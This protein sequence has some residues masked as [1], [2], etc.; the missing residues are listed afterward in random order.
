MF[1][2]IN[3]RRLMHLEILSCPIV[4]QVIHHLPILISLVSPLNLSCIFFV[5]IFVYICPQTQCVNISNVTNFYCCLN[6][7]FC[8][9]TIHFLQGNPVDCF[10]LCAHAHCIC[11]HK[12]KVVKAWP[13]VCEVSWSEELWTEYIK[14]VADFWNMTTNYV[15]HVLYHCV[16]CSCMN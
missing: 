6:K 13:Q 16:Y 4:V 10:W 8:A 5:F 14:K 9:S 1:Y 11:N 7:Y 15:L 3:K 12:C 2:N